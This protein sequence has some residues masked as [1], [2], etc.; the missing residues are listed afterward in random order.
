MK[1]LSIRQNS[2]AIREALYMDVTRYCEDKIIFR[3]SLMLNILT[4][5][6]DTKFFRLK[7]SDCQFMKKLFVTVEN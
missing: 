2:E 1:F 3:I 6:Q 7:T 4:K 5:V